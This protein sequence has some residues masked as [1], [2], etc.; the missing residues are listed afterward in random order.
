MMLF[1][2]KYSAKYDNKF[3]HINETKNQNIYAL[4]LKDILY[5]FKN[6]NIN[7]K[8]KHQQQILLLVKLRAK[9]CIILLQTL[10]AESG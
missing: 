7:F 3:L 6:T 8:F 2:N 4:F 5:Y 1:Y 10:M 9:T